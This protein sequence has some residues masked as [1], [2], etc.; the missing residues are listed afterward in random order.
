[1]RIKDSNSENELL[2][3]LEIEEEFE[4]PADRQVRRA[5]MVERLRLL[6]RERRLLARVTLWGL[7]ISTALAFV[8]PARYESAARLMPPD[9][10][11]GASAALLATVAGGAGGSALGGFAG[12]LLGFKSS[13][14]LFVGILQ[15]RTVQDRVVDQFRLM[16]VYGE[17]RREDARDEL[18]DH[19][20]ISEDRKSGIV[21][22]K[23][24]DKNPQRAAAM[25]QAYV[26]EL[27]RLVAEVST[28]AARRERVFLEQRLKSV[29][30]ELDSAARSFSQFASKNAA[31]DIKEQ[32][33][34]MLEAAA[35]LQGQLIAAEAELE[36]VREVYTENNVRVRAVRA[37]IDELKR[38]LNKLGG[39]DIDGATSSAANGNVQSASLYPSIRELPLLGVTYADLFRRTKIAEVV[40]ELLTRQYELARVQEAK[41]IP[42]VKVLDAAHVP[43]KK[44]FPP[45]TLFVFFGLSISLACGVV[46]ILGSDHWKQIDGEDPSK[47]FAEEVISVL[48]EKRTRSMGEMWLAVRG[49]VGG[50]F[51]RRPWGRRRE[52]NAD[53]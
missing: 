8:I 5:R 53:S 1:M 22:L 47:A 14:A 39:A 15:S 32:G 42:S 28:S 44:S 7:V 12:D 34:A 9:P 6:W 33:R 48:K 46:W 49:S 13:S 38:Q 27:D 18:A 23:V 51:W 3:P 17:S 35:V 10:Q 50:K 37:R 19:T 11:S 52:G 4:S 36:G 24:T 43:D 21:T 45:R 30:D 26:D 29:K 31:I 40:Y 20:R 41:E 16:D 25:A 2:E